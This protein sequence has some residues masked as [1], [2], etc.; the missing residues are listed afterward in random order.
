MFDTLQLH[1][2]RFLY[3]LR[4]DYL[5]LNNVVFATALLI[6]LSW[7]WN[8]VESMQQNYQLQQSVDRKK[9]Q[10]VLEQLQVDTLQL[11]SRYYDTLEYQE[12]AVRQRLGKGMPGERALIL[13]ST[14]STEAPQE[15]ATAASPQTSN[16]QEL[17]NFLFGQ[18]QKK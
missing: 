14:D 13:P 11:E 1:L 3:R 10:L 8:S 6:A 5:T 12:L 17:M 18:R 4:H 15:T 7:T 9:Q 2:K 16:F